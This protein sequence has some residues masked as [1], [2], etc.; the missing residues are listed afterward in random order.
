MLVR[1]IK[2]KG[3]PGVFVVHEGRARLRW[4]RL[5]RSLGSRIEVWGGLALG[6]SVVV[7]PESLRDG[8]T[9]S[10]GS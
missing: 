2:T 8:G 9:V 7:S 5:G 10:A 3:T 4:V 1:K 6:D